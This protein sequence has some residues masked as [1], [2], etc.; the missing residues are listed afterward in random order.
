M[1]ADS[2]LSANQRLDGSAEGA[3]DVVGEFKSSQDRGGKN[4]GSTTLL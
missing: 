1:P 2:R 4:I 3:D